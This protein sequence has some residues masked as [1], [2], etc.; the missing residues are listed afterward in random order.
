MLRLRSSNMDLTWNA[1]LLWNQHQHL[2][3]V[4]LWQQMTKA[5]HAWTK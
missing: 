2:L 3:A 1:L 4:V 5:K